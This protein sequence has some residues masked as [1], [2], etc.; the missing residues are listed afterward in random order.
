M[1]TYI[2]TKH[3]RRRQRR[4][5]PHRWGKD[6]K[7]YVDLA[8]T[9]GVHEAVPL[10]RF[11]V[12]S[13]MINLSCYYITWQQFEL[14]H[15]AQEY[16]LESDIRAADVFFF[17]S[18]DFIPQWR[19]ILITNIIQRVRS[20]EYCVADWFYISFVALFYKQILEGCVEK[21]FIALLLKLYCFHK[22]RG[23]CDEYGQF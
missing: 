3:K 6:A 11:D 15:A 21:E 1:W 9:N 17:V 14:H 4:E 7:F 13:N 19:P 5:R 18:T 22:V 23:C 12:A 2:N 16:S 8:S 10:Y 20:W